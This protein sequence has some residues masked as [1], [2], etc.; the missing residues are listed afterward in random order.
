MEYSVYLLECSDK[1]IYVGVTNDYQ[2]RVY[3]HETGIHPDS[4]TFSR[5]PV[6]LIYVASFKDIHDAI[7]WEKHVKRWSREKKLALA[8]N[9]ENALHVLA[10]KKFPPRFARHLAG[11]RLRR[12]QQIR[13]SLRLRL[14][15]TVCLVTPIAPQSA[16]RHDTVKF[17]NAPRYARVF[18]A[19]YSG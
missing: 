18:N 17:I 19:S 3:E 5:R 4:Y 10:K 12:L 6:R 15:R 1:T 16:T 11:I 2:K 14:H 9:N 7:A 8:Q 13:F